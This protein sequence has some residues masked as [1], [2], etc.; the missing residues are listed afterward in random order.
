MVEHLLPSEAQK[1]LNSQPNGSIGV[2]ELDRV[3]ATY[4]GYRKRSDDESQEITVRVLD[5]GPEYSAHRFSCLVTTGDG[6]T[7]VSNL[8]ESIELALG[9]ISGW[10]NLDPP[11]PPAPPT[12]RDKEVEQLIRRV[13]AEWAKSKKSP[14][15]KVGKKKKPR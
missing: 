9:T 13:A 5:R 14:P 1:H 10:R 6:T 15:A 3:V 11:A 8:A 7:A 2:F 12:E 4:I